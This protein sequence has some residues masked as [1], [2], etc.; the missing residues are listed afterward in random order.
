MLVKE[1]KSK[2][3]RKG[4]LKKMTR[5]IPK[6]KNIAMKNETWLQEVWKE[7]NLEC[8]EEMKK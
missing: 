4:K 8:R 7:G 6:W 3:S 2:R 1:N 5:R